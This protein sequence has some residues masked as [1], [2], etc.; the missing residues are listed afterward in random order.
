MKDDLFSFTGSSVSIAWVFLAF[1]I[2]HS[3][4]GILFFSL[5]CGD[6]WPGLPHMYHLPSILEKMYFIS[7][8]FNKSWLFLF[9]FSFPCWTWFLLLLFILYLFVVLYVINVLIASI[10]VF[11]NSSFPIPFP[12]HKCLRTLPYFSWFAFLRYLYA[13]NFS[14]AS[15]Y[16]PEF[17]VSST[18]LYVS[19]LLTYFVL[20]ELDW[21]A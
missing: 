17:F 21:I 14:Q 6:L 5:H 18:G 11:G 3:S 19:I 1:V 12:S 7:I 9:W 10:I 4:L 20:R 13:E 15:R 8:L 2:A 16:N